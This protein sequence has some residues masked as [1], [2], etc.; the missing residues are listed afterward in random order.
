MWCLAI[1]CIIRNHTDAACFLLPNSD[2]TAEFVVGTQRREKNE[3]GEL[4]GR[5]ETVVMD[6]PPHINVFVRLFDRSFVRAFVLSG[7]VRC[8]VAL[9]R[10]VPWVGWQASFS[11]R[12]W[13]LPLFLLVSRVERFVC[14]QG[15]FV[16]VLFLVVFLWSFVLGVFC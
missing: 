13:L 8:W 3:T 10:F 16:G 9:R 6:P 11:G 4:D 15:V 5:D 7:G 12:A 1:I 14:R 2:E